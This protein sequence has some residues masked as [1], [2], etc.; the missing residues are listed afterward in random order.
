[1]TTI[2]ALPRPAGPAAPAAVRVL[3][4]ATQPL[5]AYGL[6]ALVAHTSGLA[7]CGA[8]PS[9]EKA[10]PTLRRLHPHV[11][12]VDSRIDG[13][14]R[15]IHALRQARP[16]VRVIGLVHDDQATAT[17]YLRA[18]RAAQVN[19]LVS[20]SAA[21]AVLV[22][23]IRTTHHERAFLDPQLAPLL[24]GSEVTGALPAQAVRLTPRQLEILTR[25][26]HGLRNAEIADELG[27]SVET[28]RT[29]A[30]QIMH[31]LTA[32]DRAHAVARGYQLGLLRTPG[33]AAPRPA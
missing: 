12:L 27:I 11:V 1:M 15:G 26:A 21:P 33:T 32:R 6:R 10:L 3:V 13:D 8:A 17:G 24:A 14:A 4:I 18:A 19:G 20:Q 22:A 31:R 16:G 5:A 29:H 9:A 28:I 25:I 7:W 2:E 23:A 30:K